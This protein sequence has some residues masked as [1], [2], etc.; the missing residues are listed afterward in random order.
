MDVDAREALDRWWRVAPPDDRTTMLDLGESEDV[1]SH[2]VDLMER[3]GVRIVRVGDYVTRE[4]SP[5]AQ[6]P[7]L[8][9]FLEEKR[10]ERADD[11]RA[12]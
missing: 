10:A 4:A 11:A 7:A 12:E 5:V 2:V 6:W 9:E 3:A 8:R 1:P